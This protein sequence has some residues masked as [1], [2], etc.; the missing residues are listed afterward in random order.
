[1][2][3]TDEMAA[4]CIFEQGKSFGDLALL[5]R[6]ARLGTV[7]SL[8][9]CFF[10]AINAEAYERLLKKDKAIKLASIVNFLRQIPYMQ[11]WPVKELEVFLQ[12][13]KEK[14]IESRETVM[15]KEGTKCD[16]V[17][18]IIEGEV[19]ICKLSLKSVYYN[20]NSGTLAVSKDNQK[21]DLL[22]SNWQ[23]PQ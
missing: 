13:L 23:K 2:N 18:I 11:N 8:T 6:Q 15:A 10:A 20:H 7:I 9:D 16:K 14:T 21:S 12:Y 3:E 22:M 1:M 17:F 5:H 4:E 19:Q